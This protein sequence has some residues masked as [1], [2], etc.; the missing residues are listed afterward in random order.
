MDCYYTCRE[1]AERLIRVLNDDRA[2]TRVAD[3]AAGRG[4]LLRAARERWPSA[5]IIAV[6]LNTR[7]VAKLRRKNPNWRVGRCN[8]L[9]PASRKR[10]PVLTELQG[11]L[12]LVVLNP[13]FSYRGGCRYSASFDGSR[14][15]CGPA[16]AFVLA[17]LPYLR[18]DGDLLAVLPAGLL[19]TEKDEKARELLRQRFDLEVVATNGRSAFEGCYPRTILVHLRACR[20][21][22]RRDE[23]VPSLKIA[24][25]QCHGEIVVKRGTVQMHSVSEDLPEDCLPL[26][27][28][29]ELTGSKIN[30][31]RRRA[32][33]GRSVVRGPAVLLPRVGSPCKEKVGLYLSKRPLVISDCVFALVCKDSQHA[34][35]VQKV[36]VNRWAAVEKEYGGTCAAYLTVRAL[37]RLCER[38]SFRVKSV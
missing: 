27:H 31:K 9:D 37:M 7:A 32:P 28:S 23:S 4:E 12:S 11:Q 21:L 8:F 33:S 18:P 24:R 35:V 13:P 22:P 26:V 6:D 30:T 15:T 10:T 5:E 29:T 1:L 16:M 2:V 17:S 3:F 25:H 34:K 20:K 14:V 36:F 19:K 38:F